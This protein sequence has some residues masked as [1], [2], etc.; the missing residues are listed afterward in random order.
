MTVTALRSSGR[1]VFACLFLLIACPI[2]LWLRARQ[3]AY[4]PD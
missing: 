2:S 1:F 3:Q 4:R